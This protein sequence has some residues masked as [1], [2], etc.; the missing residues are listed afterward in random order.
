MASNATHR[1]PPLLFRKASTESSPPPSPN[2]D[3]LPDQHAAELRKHRSSLLFIEGGHP[4]RPLDASSGNVRPAYIGRQ[5]TPPSPPSSLFVNESEPMDSATQRP[6]FAGEPVE[7]TPPS[8]LRDKF[9][10]VFKG[11]RRGSSEATSS[12]R[13]PIA[14]RPRAETLSSTNSA[15]NA[16]APTLSSRSSVQQSEGRLTEPNSRHGSGRRQATNSGEVRIE[17]HP[18]PWVVPRPAVADAQDLDE[19]GSTKYYDFYT[20]RTAARSENGDEGEETEKRRERDWAQNST[21]YLPPIPGSA[22]TL[23]P[24]FAQPNLDRSLTMQSDHSSASQERKYAEEAT[25][26]F[27]FEGFHFGLPEESGQEHASASESVRGSRLGAVPMAIDPP[28][29]DSSLSHNGTGFCSSS[30]KASSSVLDPP[31]RSNSSLGAHPSMRSVSATSGSKIT[32]TGAGRPAVGRSFSSSSYFVGGVRLPSA[33]SR[34]SDEVAKELKRLSKISAGSGM[35]G[36]AIVVAADGAGDEQEIG[37]KWTAE[38]K[39]KGKAPS[40]HEHGRRRHTRSGVSEWTDGNEDRSVS[41]DNDDSRSLLR[42]SKAIEVEKKLKSQ[43]PA[44]GV[45]IHQGDQRYD[46]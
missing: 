8:S 39:G 25:S 2:P 42:E 4:A 14:R 37:T 27:G 16:L 36:L 41:E 26:S 23:S 21:P 31:A 29:A 13:A 22:N 3:L 33:N 35:S 28:R 46:L 30:G 6:R 11:H 40:P 17:I 32:G 9:S 43:E 45:I 12:T 7:Q 19:D 15:R 5:V 10:R 18:R 24:T 38:E 44:S 20:G 1:P 34:H